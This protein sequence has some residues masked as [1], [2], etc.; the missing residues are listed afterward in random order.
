MSV[1]LKTVIDLINEFGNENLVKT[2]LKK[3]QEIDEKKADDYL[4]R[5]DEEYKKYQDMLDKIYILLKECNFE[6]IINSMT[7]DYK[8]EVEKIKKSIV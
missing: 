1:Y 8:I 5:G 4:K 6:N 3:E 2:D 7:V